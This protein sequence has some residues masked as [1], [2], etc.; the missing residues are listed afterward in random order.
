MVAKELGMSHRTLQ[1]RITDEGSTFRQLLNETRWYG[2]RMPPNV[3]RFG[4]G[5][6]IDGWLV[7]RKILSQESLEI[8]AVALLDTRFRLI[9][10]EQIS[11]GILNEA[12]A[13]RAKS[14]SRPSFIPLTPLRSYIITHRGTQLRVMP[15]CG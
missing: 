4:Y 10:K 1:R 6:E 2:G 5:S 11:V 13:H 3:S 12:L 8:L 9:K 15:T 14:L 7:E